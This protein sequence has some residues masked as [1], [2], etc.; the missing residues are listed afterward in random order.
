MVSRDPETTWN[1]EKDGS[2]ETREA[3]M[4]RE[5]FSGNFPLLSGSRTFVRFFEYESNLLQ[6]TEVVKFDGVNRNL[7][8][9]SESSHFYKT[10]EIARRSFF[11]S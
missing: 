4:N 8:A 2:T 3:P 7:I 1:Q 5:K 6:F 10:V 11:A 9:T